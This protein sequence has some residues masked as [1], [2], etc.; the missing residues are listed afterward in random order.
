MPLLW[1]PR[2]QPMHTVR[3]SPV[4]LSRH[5]NR[6]VAE[7]EGRGGQLASCVEICTATDSSIQAIAADH[8]RC[9]RGG[10][11]YTLTG[12]GG[13][14][15]PGADR[16][17]SVGGVGAHRH[18]HVDGHV[19]AKPDALLLLELP[20]GV[21]D[22]LVAERGAAEEGHER[23]DGRWEHHV[24]LALAGRRDGRRKRRHRRAS[25]HRAG[26]AGPRCPGSCAPQPPRGSGG[27][28][29]LSAQ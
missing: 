12:W 16:S 29:S 20:H 2:H 17:D 13:A 11:P 14:V 22:D 1:Q 15:G 10:P 26:S 21:R 24:A 8:H 23:E 5:R 9:A 25:G 7:A 6:C 27:E 28:P 18:A 4:E 3:I 19:E